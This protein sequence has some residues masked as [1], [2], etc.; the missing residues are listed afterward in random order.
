MEVS[1]GAFL[2]AQTYNKGSLRPP[3]SVKPFM[4]ITRI[5]G[6]TRF[7]HEIERKKNISEVIINAFCLMRLT[8]DR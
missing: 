1:Q 2:S 4:N 3:L 5:V 6:I 8:A 7:P